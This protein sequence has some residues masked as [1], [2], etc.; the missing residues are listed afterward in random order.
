MYY[1]GLLLGPEVSTKPVPCST[2]PRWDQWINFD[3]LYISNI[4]RVSRPLSLAGDFISYFFL[5]GGTT[6]HDA[7]RKV[8]QGLRTANRAGLG[9][10]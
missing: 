2:N 4:P 3:D 10:S 9:Q 6:V 7:I 8:T 5:V 1:G